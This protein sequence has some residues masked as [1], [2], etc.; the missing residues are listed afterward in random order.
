[1]CQVRI[2]TPM[3]AG[4][5]DVLM[6]ENLLERKDYRSADSMITRALARPDNSEETRAEAL[7]GR[8]QVYYAAGNDTAVVA[9]CASVY[10]LRVRHETWIPPNACYLS[11]LAYARMGNSDEA[12]AAFRK[13]K[14]FSDY[15]NAG[16]LERQIAEQEKKLESP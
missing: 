8:A 14:R 10:G 12:R 9:T 13:A 7:Y 3:S 1:M 2:E 11:G 6:A 5:V 16:S 4:D 15:D